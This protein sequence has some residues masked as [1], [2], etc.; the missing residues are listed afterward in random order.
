MNL[1]LIAAFDEDRNI[2]FKNKLPWNIKEEM[3]SFKRLTENNIVIMGKN[4]YRSLNN[5]L[6]NRMNLVISS[7]SKLKQENGIYCF[8]DVVSALNYCKKINLNKKIF[9]I[10]GKMLYEYCLKNNLIKYMYISKIKGVYEGDTKFP[11]FK[12]N[13]WTHSVVESYKE[14][15]LCLYQ[16]V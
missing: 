13:D 8:E 2:G 4:T 10:G 5:P 16:K 1:Y 3:C 6:K 11:E 7:E 9:I 12:E 14:F 15:D